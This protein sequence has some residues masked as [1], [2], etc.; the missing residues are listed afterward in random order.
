MEFHVD[1][2]NAAFI[3]GWGRDGSAPITLMLIVNG[4]VIA[5]AVANE[6]RHDLL[7]AGFGSGHL[8]YSFKL[9]RPYLATDDVIEIKNAATGAVLYKSP[10]DLAKTSGI[11]AAY[12]LLNKITFA[13]PFW[14]P[15]LF[16]AGAGKVSLPGRTIPAA[17][18]FN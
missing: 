17:G 13:G 12:D 5:Q 9:R 7:Q 1:Q 8:G 15:L 2:L 18:E 16:D 4:S 3:S 14:R 11:D 6:Y 10:L